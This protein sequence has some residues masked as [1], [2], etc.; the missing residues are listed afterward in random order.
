M[1]A[2]DYQLLRSRWWPSTD[3]V[4][5]WRDLFEERASVRP[6]ESADVWRAHLTAQL[7]RVGG[8]RAGVDARL[9][10]IAR[11]VTP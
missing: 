11:D 3:D 9:R 8:R 5:A 2:D 10:R 6:H 1:A 7:K 4:D